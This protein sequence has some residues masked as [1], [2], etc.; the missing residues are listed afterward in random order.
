MTVATLGAE[1]RDVRSTDRQPRV[2]EA[3]T[4][5]V[6]NFNGGRLLCDTVTSIKQ[7][8]H[9]PDEI[10]IVDDGSTDD[11]LDLL[12]RRHPDVR[13]VL[14]P[15]LGRPNA[16][17]TVALQAASHRY[18]LLSDNDIRFAPGAIQ[19]L[20]DALRRLPDAAVCTPLVVSDEDPTEIMARSRPLHFLCWATAIEPR[21]VREAVAEG[22][23]RG[24]GGGIQ[25]VDKERIRP[26]GTF[27]GDLA[28][29]WSDGEFHLRLQIAGRP[30]YSVPSALVFHRRVRSSPRVYGQ[31]HN[32]WH[33]MLKTYELR[34]LLLIAPA[35]AVFELMLL[36]FAVKAGT[37]RDYFRAHRDILHELGDIRRKRRAIQSTRRVRDRDILVAAELDLPRYMEDKSLLMA[38]LHLISSGFRAYWKIVRPLV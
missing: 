29:G 8:A 17:R 4:A 32:R 13:I 14:M 24:I 11:S 25:L 18:V 9:R 26:A 28:F 38:A 7:L 16:V 23:R 34:T 1:P 10:V 30:C 35:L 15:H 27:D 2:V 20:M 5:A 3:W 12:R 37:G 19:P 22:P 21:H 6:I 31:L 36:V 33:I